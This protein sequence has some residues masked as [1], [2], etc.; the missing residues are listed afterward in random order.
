[1]KPRAN[2][3]ITRIDQPEKKNHG[4]NV[5]ISWEGTLHRRYFADKRYGGRK[6]S[7]ALAHEFRDA[8]LASLPEKAR[9]RACRSKPQKPK[10]GVQGVLYVTTHPDGRGNYRYRYWQATWVDAQ[11]HQRTAKFSVDRYG[12]EVAL[13]KAKRAMRVAMIALRKAAP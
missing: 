7:L 11:G 5:R 1:M 6:R 3:G 2:Y 10:S 4:F 9:E 12:Y 8:V 13:E